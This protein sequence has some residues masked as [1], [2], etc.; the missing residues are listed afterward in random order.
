[1]EVQL[2]KTHGPLA[3]ASFFLHMHDKVIMIALY[4]P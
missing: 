3:L 2:S 1:M 4:N